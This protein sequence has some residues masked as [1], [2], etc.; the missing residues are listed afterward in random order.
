[1]PIVL[2]VSRAPLLI[3]TAT[4]VLREAEYRDHLTQCTELIVKVGRP[5]AYVY[6]GTGIVQMP[7]SCRKLQAEWINEH[8]MVIRSLNRG[9]GFAFA[10]ALTRG[11][12]TAVHWLSPPPYP[13][14]IF[15]VRGEAIR[16]CIDQL[17]GAGDLSRG[18]ADQVEGETAS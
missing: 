18:N 13:H 10:S 12:L 1:V 4:G 5:Y 16:W 8:R 3:T 17:V 15:A 6:D 14:A 9:C 7:S 11:L 2:D